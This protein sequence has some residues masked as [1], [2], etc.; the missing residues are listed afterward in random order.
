MPELNHTIVAAKNKHESAAF[1]VDLLGLQP[2][3]EAGFFLV[4]ELDNHVS[5]D[6]AEPGA[7]FP[8]A[9][10]AFLVSDAEFDAALAKLKARGL[11][12]YPG[13]WKAN[14][15]QINTHDGGRGVYFFDPSGHGLELIT[16]PYGGWPG[17]VVRAVG[18]TKA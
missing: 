5:L 18:A 10:Y 1:Y 17:G 8:M 9:H 12:I 16:V 3:K 15:G 6:F 13:P 11:P 7:D 4:V 14:E 2:P